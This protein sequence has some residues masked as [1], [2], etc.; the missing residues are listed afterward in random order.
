MR[1]ITVGSMEHLY[2]GPD[3]LLE[4]L[5]GLPEERLALV[6]DGRCRASLE[7]LAAKLGLANRVEFLGPLPAG[8][9]VRQALDRADLFVL[10]SR[11]EGLPRAMIEAM[12]RGLP[13]IGSNVGGIGELIPA[14]CLAPAGDAQALRA[15]IRALANDPSR[16]AREA[17][18]NL[19][20]A[21]D[22]H[23]DVLRRGVRL[24][25]R[26]AAAGPRPL[27]LKQP[28]PAQPIKTT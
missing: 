3:V 12:A 11:Q 8:A 6:G 7:A 26:S 1:L 22:Y 20:C 24:L 17:A 28:S 10:P 5:A 2:K 18:A 23:E 4:A 19:A 15:K 25:R 21:R 27:E 13:C 9:A 16:L 14:D